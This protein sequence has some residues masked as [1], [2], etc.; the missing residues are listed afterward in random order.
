[1]PFNVSYFWL[2]AT[3]ASEVPTDILR[4]L[5]LTVATEF[6]VIISKESN[7]FLYD[8]YNPSYRHGAQ[9]N[10]TYMGYWNENEGLKNF[11]QQYKYKRRQDFNG[12]MFN[13]STLVRF[14]SFKIFKLL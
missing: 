1:M 3:D 5:P 10:V 8:V 7:Y 9:L 6:T 2:A 4:S 13:F 14:A 12:L 11:L